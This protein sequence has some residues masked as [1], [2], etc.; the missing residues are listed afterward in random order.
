MLAIFKKQKKK[1][2]KEQN[3]YKPSE[4]L[5]TV[6][7][8]S[9]PGSVI[10]V[11]RQNEKFRISDDD[12]GN[13]RYIVATLDVADIGGLNRHM[14]HDQDKGQFIEC[15][16]CG[17]IESYVSEE[18]IAQN[19]FVII[20]TDRTIDSLSEFSFLADKDRFENFIVTC[21]TIDKNGNMF[22]DESEQ[23]VDFNWFANISNGISELPSSWATK[24]EEE[25][26]DNMDSNQEESES[27]DNDD[28]MDR[29]D[30]QNE[31]ET[32]FDDADEKMTNETDNESESTEIEPEIEDEPESVEIGS[33]VEDNSNND[34]SEINDDEAS[35]YMD[36]EEN[37]V[38]DSQMIECPMCHNI[39]DMNEPCPTCGYDFSTDSINWESEQPSNSEMEINEEISDIDVSMAVERLFHAGDLDLEI[40]AQPFDVQFVKENKFIPISEERGDSWL[41]GY[42]TQLIKNANDE[43]AQLHKT[44]LFATRN[45]YLSIMTEECER[46][47]KS[48]DLD[49]PTNNYYKVKKALQESFSHKRDEMEAE[50]A[51]RRTSLQ[52][53]W[54]NELRM[55]E[56]SAAAGARRNYLDKHAK[57]HE[58][59][60]RSV[61]TDLN[62]EIDIEYN[63]Q[64]SELNAR[65]KTE[66][67]RLHDVAVTQTLLVI[68][69]SYEKLLN[70]E[71]E[72]RE[73]LLSEIQEYVDAHRKDEVA[74]NAV[75]AE[76]QRQKEEAVKVTEELT[77]KIDLITAEHNAACEKLQQEVR[78]AYVHEES[79]KN[80]Y[81]NR[82]ENEKCRYKELDE[83]YQD[84]MNRYVD[85]DAAKSKEYESYIN[86]LENDKKAAEEHL[87]HVDI[88]H[89]K[90]NKVSI[91]VWVAIS[92]A[93][94]A[95]GTIVGSRFLGGSNIPADG[96][97]SI[98]LTTPSQ[99]TEEMQT[100]DT[101]K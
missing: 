40:S 69:E 15:V 26:Q 98:S 63:K 78:A 34:E 75:I 46:I 81:D 61:E 28:D 71:N 25:E 23:R 84:L 95:I 6:L 2:Q 35:E 45:R 38:D 7:S 65:R 19:K 58:A 12:D 5:G 14:K 57:A 43:L 18:G 82:I 44:N 88:I 32:V 90:Y 20:P 27:N 42:V 64:L 39:I 48:V 68:G 13:S 73:Q 52:E 24:N 85:I 100:A 3:T 17:N 56:E 47:A 55:I 22:F 66:A 97:Y 9:V 76:T 77:H 79:V 91:V 72:K 51:K 4:S 29:D 70:E 1:N 36:S 11:I 54:N 94:F 16:N 89:N 96:H 33:E 74:R 67:Q 53:N 101:D 37:D 83:R 30:D 10:D 93:T 21:V 87:A 49:E 59:A 99:E 86:T 50:V 80:D 60:L 41:D 92:V 31:L 8:E 62:D